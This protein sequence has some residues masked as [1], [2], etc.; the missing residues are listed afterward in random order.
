MS[1]I[2]WL[3]GE[4]VTADSPV[5]PF[6]DGGFLRGLGVFDTLLGEN[7]IPVKAEEHFARLIDNCETCLLYKPG[8]TLDWFRDTATQLMDKTGLSEGHAR[9]RTQITA[10]ITK[11]MLGKPEK[12]LVMMMAVPVAIPATPVP[13]HAYIVEDY[14]R[15]ANCIFENC[16]RLDYTRSYFAKHKAAELGGSDAILTNTDGNIACATTSN[17]FIVENGQFITPPLS[18]GVLNGITRKAII[19]KHG[20]IEESISK[21][22]LLNA[23][24]AFLTNSILGIRPVEKIN[25]VEFSSPIPAELA[26]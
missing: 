4:F 15:I 1:K 7:G 25:D 13:V 10:G 14:P 2:I 12:P 24:N 18:D 5:I 3:N 23:E 19:Q 21:E 17:L 22:R 11:E 26:A 9:I 20:A 6:D 16:K 8:L